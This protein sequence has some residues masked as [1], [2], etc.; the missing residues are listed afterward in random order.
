MM[1]TTYM[2][3]TLCMTYMSTSSDDVAELFLAQASK[4]LR[5]FFPSRYLPAMR[6]IGSGGVSELVASFSPR[7]SEDRPSTLEVV[8]RRSVGS[9]RAPD[10]EVFV[11]NQLHT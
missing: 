2:M 6:A 8:A 9:D 1:Y 5:P 7:L 3:Y 10:S 11:G 4:W